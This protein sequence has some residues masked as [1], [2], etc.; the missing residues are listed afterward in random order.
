M[1]N[2]LGWG[3]IIPHQRPFHQFKP[4]TRSCADPSQ[5]EA[6]L[7]SMPDA[8]LQELIDFVGGMPDNEVAALERALFLS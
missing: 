2:Y 4:D 5:R 7:W 8:A 1:D 3:N 6:Y